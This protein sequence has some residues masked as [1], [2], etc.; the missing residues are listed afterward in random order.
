MKQD[1]GPGTKVPS[2]FGEAGVSLGDNEGSRNDGMGCECYLAV[3]S[4]TSLVARF[5]SA[6]L[7]G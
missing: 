6:G 2:G 5:D 3:K 1:L 4:V 7:V